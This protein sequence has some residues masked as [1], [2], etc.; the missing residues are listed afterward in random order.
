MSGAVLVSRMY[1]SIRSSSSARSRV[2]SAWA[3]YHMRRIRGRGFRPLAGGIH[4]PVPSSDRGIRRAFGG[5]GRC[6]RGTAHPIS[7]GL[8]S[9]PRSTASA[10]GGNVAVDMEFVT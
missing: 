5:P 2:S 3:L 1:E 6:I 10:P 4:A 7:R 9:A 8:S